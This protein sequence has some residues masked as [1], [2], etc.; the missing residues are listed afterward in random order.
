[1]HQLCVI[2]GDTDEVLADYAQKIDPNAYLVTADNF[3]QSHTGLVYTSLGDLRG[4]DQLLALLSKSTKII[5]L[6]P[7]KRIWS[8]WFNDNDRYSIGWLTKHYCLT[9]SKLFDIPLEMDHCDSICPEN[10]H[11]R[12]SNEPHTWIVGCSTTKGVGVSEDEIYWK[13]T[14]R[15]LGNPVVDLSRSGSSISWASDQLLRADLRKGDKIIWGI[16]TANRF[17][18]YHS[19][20]VQMINPLFYENSP[21]FKQIVPEHILVD[22]HWTYEGLAAIDRVENLCSKL[23]IGLLLAGIHANIDFNSSLAGRL[24]YVMIQGKSGL[25]W[26]SEFL[27]YGNDGLHPGPETHKMYS[28]LVFDRVKLLGW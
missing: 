24:N 27:D 25:D 26:N 17:Y 19:G 1:M 10:V 2:V 11:A 3:D 8:D 28:Q 21:D 16:T 23:D 14:A 15:Y 6:S 4:V 12:M 20:A 22:D 9:A 7:K 5:F 13:K 18:W